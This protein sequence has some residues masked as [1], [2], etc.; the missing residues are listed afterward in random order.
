M[1]TCVSLQC[2]VLGVAVIFINESVCLRGGSAE[3]N[4]QKDK[5]GPVSFKLT[6]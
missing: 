4:V 3:S 5:C 1:E 6:D 2:Q